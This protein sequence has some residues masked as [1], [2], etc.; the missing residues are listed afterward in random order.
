ML[1]NN[2]LNNELSVEMVNLR[3][4]LNLGENAAEL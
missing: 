2:S 1:Q 4:E 3:E